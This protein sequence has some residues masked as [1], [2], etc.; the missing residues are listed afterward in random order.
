[1]YSSFRLIDAIPFRTVF[2]GDDPPVDP[3]ADPP[4]DPPPSSDKSKVKFDQAQQNYVNSLLANE[5]RK[6]QTRN[7]ELITQLET[8][9]LQANTT[10]S[11]KEAL[12]SR[13]E[14]LRNEFATK[15]ELS[16]KDTDKRIKQ[17]EK[18]KSESDKKAKDHWEKYEQYKIE[19]D[20]VTAAAQGK[21]FDPEQIVAIL[22]PA[23]KLVEDTGDGGKPT[24]V[25]NTRV[26]LPGTNKDNQPITL[27]LSPPEA[28]KYLAEKPE[29]YGNLFISGATGGLGS[30]NQGKT[31]D[32]PDPSKMSTSEYMEHRR[33]ERAGKR[34]GQ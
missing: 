19:N 29:K 1:M 6:L 34:P 26:R 30:S 18:E 20:L 13:I 24:G 32:K 15:E 25:F 33:K 7:E 4:A 14:T 9:K 21:A 8:Q 3:P 17:L 12:E 28:I 5:R 11:E 16:K 27:D 23:T 22:R 10:Q 31:G 2:E